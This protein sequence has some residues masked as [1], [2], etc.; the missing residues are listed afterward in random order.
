MKK[1]HLSHECWQFLATITSKEY[2][3]VQTEVCQ[4][5]GISIFALIVSHINL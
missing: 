2:Q 3:S 1:P 4:F 5:F